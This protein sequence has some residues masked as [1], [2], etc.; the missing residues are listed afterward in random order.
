[1]YETIILNVENRVATITL[2]R[3][4][5]G[6]AFIPKSYE[7]IRQ[8]LDTCAQNDEVG[9][10]VLTGAGKHFSAGGDI[11][12]FKRLIETKEY[13]IKG[14]ILEAGKMALAVRRCPKPVIAMINGAAAGAGAGLALACDFRIMEPK[15]KLAMSF[16]NMGLSG[17]T[18]T[19]FSCLRLLGT[20]KAME[21]MM[22]GDLITGEEALQIGL[23]TIL[24]KQDQ[25][26]QET[27]A[28]AQKMANRPLYAIARQKEILLEFFYSN[29]DVYTKREAECMVECS[30]TADFEEAVNAFLEK[31]S[32]QFIGK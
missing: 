11:Q 2:N 20:A 10:I 29:M 27:Y 1:M 9:S 4:K 24:T 6:N 21:L 15:S 22:T 25:L 30:H 12:R 32:P 3:P 26:E 5:S 17:D 7:E 23:A 28:Y 31:R 18:C 13:L 14:S 19:M 16:I 8:A